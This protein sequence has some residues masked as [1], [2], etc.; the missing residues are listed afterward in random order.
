MPLPRGIDV[1]GA[2]VLN[3][4]LVLKSCDV[5]NNSKSAAIVGVALM[6]RGDVAPEAVTTKSVWSIAVP[7]SP[8]KT[9]L[10]FSVAQA[11]AIVPPGGTMGEF[12]TTISLGAVKPTLVIPLT[13][14][15]C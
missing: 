7:L 5:N 3:P 13:V 6:E 14:T 12:E 2:P 10:A 15:T 1:Q 8:A 9:V 11:N 4:L